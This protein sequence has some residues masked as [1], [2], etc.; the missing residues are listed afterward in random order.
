MAL[1]EEAAALST[2]LRSTRHKRRLGGTGK[3]AE[4]AAMVECRKK[5]WS[6][7]A[8]VDGQ[9]GQYRYIFSKRRGRGRANPQRGAFAY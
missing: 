4:K 3:S 2:P 8:E 5:L 9:E 6:G 1:A 7:I